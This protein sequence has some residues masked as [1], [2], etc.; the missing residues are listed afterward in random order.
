MCSRYLSSMNNFFF[1]IDPYEDSFM[2]CSM[3]KAIF[4]PFCDLE[5]FA[6]CNLPMYICIL[7]RQREK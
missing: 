4:Q 2:I 1:S 5:M 3:F 7:V 6:K